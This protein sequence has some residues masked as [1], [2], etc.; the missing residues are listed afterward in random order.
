MRRR[1][2]TYAQIVLRLLDDR[3]IEN[4]GPDLALRAADDEG[5][6]DESNRRHRAHDRSPLLS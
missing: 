2:G 1:A 4:R 6:E 3:R 5:R